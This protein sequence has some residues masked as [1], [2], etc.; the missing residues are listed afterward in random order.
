[1]NNFINYEIIEAMDMD[2][3]FCDIFQILGTSFVIH[4]TKSSGIYLNAENMF[5][6]N[7]RFKSNQIPYTNGCDEKVRPTVML[8]VLVIEG[9][10]IYNHPVLLDLFNLKFHI[11]VPYEICYERRK[12]RNYAVPDIP[13]Y[14]ELFVYPYYEKHM[15]EYEH[16]EEII[17]LSGAKNPEKCFDYVKNRIWSDL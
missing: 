4:K 7:Y 13:K 6:E 12:N 10:L 5:R 9:F 16:R 15:K 17:A 8:N 11:H 14:F 2:K 1:M 3:M